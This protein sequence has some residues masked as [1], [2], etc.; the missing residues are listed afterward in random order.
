MGTSRS[1]SHQQKSGCSEYRRWN[2]RFS[3]E[4]SKLRDLRDDETC[5]HV[6]F[7]WSKALQWPEFL[8][9]IVPNALSGATSCT[10]ERE[11]HRLRAFLAG[12]EVDLQDH[13]SDSLGLV[14][15]P[16]KVWK[17]CFKCV[18]FGHQQ[19]F[20][21]WRERAQKRYNIFGEISLTNAS[22][23]GTAYV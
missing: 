18:F 22:I 5:C 7:R 20:Q 9:D 16:T 15:R 23:L 6:C 11:G 4:F 13:F 12:K 8:W 14:P 21:D 17:R 1:G 3:T 10:T 2:C 19:C